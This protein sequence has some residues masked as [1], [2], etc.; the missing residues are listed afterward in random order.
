MEGS[1]LPP[2]PLP[3]GDTSGSTA[4]IHVASVGGPLALPS[5]TG[6]RIDLRDLDLICRGLVVAAAA[7]RIH[8][9]HDGW[10]VTHALV[11][12]RRQ[13]VYIL[14]MFLMYDDSNL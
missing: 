3:P 14:M 5:Y 10:V 13:S 8:P 4:A 7:N 12:S 2:S 6:V 9:L 11:L 1:S